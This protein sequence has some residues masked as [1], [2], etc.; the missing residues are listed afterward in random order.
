MNKLLGDTS[1][2]AETHV[3]LYKVC[4]SCAHACVQ[5]SGVVRARGRRARPCAQPL[6]P[7]D[8]MRASRPPPPA[9]AGGRPLPAAAALQGGHQRKGEPHDRHSSGCGRT[10]LR[11]GRGG[12]TQDAAQ[13]RVGA[14]ASH[15]C[16][17]RAP[18]SLPPSHPLPPTPTPHRYEK[19]MLRRIDWNQRRED[20][21]EEEEEEEEGE[22][23]EAKP[24]NYCHLVWQVGREGGVG[25]RVRGGGEEEGQR[26]RSRPAHCRRTRRVFMC[27]L[28]PPPPP[29]HAYTQT[30]REWS[31]RRALKS[32]RWRR[33]RARP[34]RASSST[35]SA[36]RT[37]GTCAQTTHPTSERRCCKHHL[38]L[39]GWVGAC[40][41]G[42]G[43]VRRTHASWRRL[44][45]Q[46]ARARR[47]LYARP[48]PPDTTH[49]LAQHVA[50]LLGL[51]DGASTLGIAAS[52]ARGPA[53][54]IHASPPQGG[55][56]TSPAAA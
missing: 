6:S 46:L 29:P 39:L 26:V 56:S 15:A 35:R 32:S 10:V 16:R 52:R 19:L 1:G 2:V 49:A 11:G 45:M 28:P 27:T 50:R 33:W 9:L 25:G 30:P 53:A 43:R 17:R 55:C 42:G 21:E 13:A 3:A 31:R 36:A 47:R 18:R 14:W 38:P 5:D 41:V 12:A 51:G 40:E 37:T 44:T 48:P 24:P 4:V 22:G 34:R 8:L 20:E 54:C 23:G 7:L